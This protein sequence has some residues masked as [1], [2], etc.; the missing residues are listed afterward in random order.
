MKSALLSF[1]F[2]GGMMTSFFGSGTAST[3][4][5][6]SIFGASSFLGVGTVSIT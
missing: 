1:F 6:F 4:L 5:V 2:L 3:D